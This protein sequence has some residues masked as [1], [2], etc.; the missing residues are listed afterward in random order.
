MYVLD[1]LH[2][3]GKLVVPHLSHPRILLYVLLYF[4]SIKLS[5][6]E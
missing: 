3:L 6:L 5:S 2:K 4:D 1:C